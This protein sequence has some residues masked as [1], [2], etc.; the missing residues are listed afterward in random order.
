MEEGMKRAERRNHE[1]DDYGAPCCT[2][3]VSVVVTGS[4]AA[5]TVELLPRRRLHLNATTPPCFTFT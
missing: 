1:L 5:R 3:W 2:A 4:T